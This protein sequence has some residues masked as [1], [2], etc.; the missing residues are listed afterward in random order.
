MPPT[1]WTVGHSTRSLQDF[2]AILRAY[3][4]EALAD[5]R[6]FPASRRLPH[7]QERV[8]EDALEERGIA[9]LW[10]PALGGRRR[11]G[12]APSTTAWRHPAFQ[13]YADHLTT[14]EFA[15]GLVDLLMLCYG[16]RTVVMCA[17]ALWWRC[18]RRLIADVLVSLGIDVVHIQSADRA[19]PHR[20]GPPAALVHGR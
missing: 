8:L 18:H 1:V 12:P 5:V 7:F 20:I 6:R 14:E 15:S 4:V 2:L 11:A 9:Y 13:A 16:L 3:D 19:E 10:L 17:E